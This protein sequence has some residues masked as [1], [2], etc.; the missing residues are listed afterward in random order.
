[1]ILHI[2]SPKSSIPVNI[3][4]QDIPVNIDIQDRSR[5]TMIHLSRET[6]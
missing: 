5:E 3:D 1:M 4:I 6:M 2:E